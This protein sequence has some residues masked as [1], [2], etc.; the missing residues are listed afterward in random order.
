M[1]E[2]PRSACF[3]GVCPFATIAEYA[4]THGNET[5]AEARV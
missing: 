1:L 5:M 3:S 2:F 4:I